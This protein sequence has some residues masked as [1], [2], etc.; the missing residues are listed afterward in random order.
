MFL[1]AVCPP[2]WANLED[3]WC[4]QGVDTPVSFP[5]AMS[6]CASLHPDARLAILDSQQKHDFVTTAFVHM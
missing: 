2:S 5:I 3:H 6:Q 4:Y 1:S